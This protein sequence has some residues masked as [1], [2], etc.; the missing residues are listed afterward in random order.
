MEITK[1]TRPFVASACKLGKLKWSFQNVH[2]QKAE[3]DLSLGALTPSSQ[4]KPPTH[5]WEMQMILKT[6]AKGHRH[7][8]AADYWHECAVDLANQKVIL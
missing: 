3:E 2:G 5:A 6:K 4:G 1:D 7:R 8:F